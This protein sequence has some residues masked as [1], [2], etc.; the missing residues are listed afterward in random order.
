M[1]FHRNPGLEVIN[2]LMS[3]LHEN[4]TMEWETQDPPRVRLDPNWGV[5]LVSAHKFCLLLFG[6]IL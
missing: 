5:P 6:R 4:S 3:Q 2:L 1:F